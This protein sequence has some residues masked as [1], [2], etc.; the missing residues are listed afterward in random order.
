MSMEC[1]EEHKKPTIRYR[2]ARVVL[3]LAIHC[4]AQPRVFL[5]IHKQTRPLAVIR[6]SCES[7]VDGN[8]D[9]EFS[10][11]WSVSTL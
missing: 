9:G 5:A 4:R 3:G 2:D 7:A 8:F 10:I 6:K 11:G 1:M